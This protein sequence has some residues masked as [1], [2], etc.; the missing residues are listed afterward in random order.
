MKTK[1]LIYTVLVALLP[2]FSRFFIWLVMKTPI[3][4][5]NTS[6]FIGFGLIMHISI[7]NQVEHRMN[8]EKSWK[9]IQNGISV[10]F[11]AFYSILFSLNIISNSISKSFDINTI[12]YCSMILSLISFFISFSV[13]HR[14]SKFPE[15]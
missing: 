9:T 11:I 6:D 5:F 4:L 1:W 15:A 3:D 2:I 14:M 8:E 7:I 12:K 13:F 10:S